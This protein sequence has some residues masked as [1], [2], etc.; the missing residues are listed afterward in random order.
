MTLSQSN[1]RILDVD[2]QTA[3]LI[4]AEERRQREKLILIPSESWTPTP[5]REALGSVLTSVY[6]EGY[7]RRAMMRQTVEQLADLDVQLANFR[8]YADRRFYKGVEIADLVESLAARRAAECFAT[9]DIPA[10]RIYANVQALSG[11]AANLAVYEAFVTPGET[12]MGMALT[13]GGHLTHGSE[14]NIT[15][16]RYR[17][18][19]YAVDPTTGR[20]D[21]DQIR[22]LAEKHRPRMIIGGFTSYPWQADWA[23]FREIADSVGAILLADVAHTA[24][25]IVGGVY[26][27]PIG[28]AHVVSFTTHKTL[29]GGRGAVLLSTDPAI[30]A[31]LDSSIFPGQQG[32]PHVNKFA[33]LAVA[34][35]LAQQ[36]EFS[37]LQRR[38]VENA[39][40]LA[41][42]LA[43]NGLTLAYGGT[44]TH[45]LLVDLRPLPRDTR[46]VMMGEIA[47]RIL[48]LAGI[49]CNKNT[50]PGDHSAADAHGIRLGTP[51]VTQRGMGEAEMR[52]LA[53]IIAD[54]LKA[55]RPFSYCGLRGDSSR[56]KILLPALEAAKRDVRELIGRV[57]PRGVAPS[58]DVRP[59]TNGG[60]SAT[61]VRG[62]RAG[63]LLQES[64]TVD[65]F[66]LPPGGAAPAYLFDEN[67]HA[68]SNVIV[69]ALGRDDY[70]LYTPAANARAVRE[71]LTGLSDGYAI[72]DLRDVLCKIQGPAVI[73]EVAPGALP[74]SAQAWKPSAAAEDAAGAD[75]REAF[76]KHP[77]RFALRKPYFVA[78]RRLPP[79]T[80]SAPPAEFRWNAA[81]EPPRR[82][83]LYDA[84]VALG[85]KL[86]PF[87]GWEMPVWYTSALEEHA[88]VRSAAGLFDLGH[89]GVFQI[90]GDRAVDFLDAV[91]SNYAGWLE[92]GQSQYAYLFDL[93]GRVID[94][95]MVYR[96]ARNRF[97]VVVNAAN[98]QK[99]WDWLCGVNEGTYLIDRE[100]PACSPCPP[101][102]IRDLKKERGVV[103]V[104]IQGPKSR[105]ILD[106]VLGPQ[107]RLAT[108]TLDRTQF[109]EV[110]PEGHQLLVART[111]YTGEPVGYEIYS[112]APDAAWL[113]SRLLDL[114]RP[115]GLLPC[116]LA[117]RDSTRTEAGLPLYG[118]ELAGPHE[119][120][121]YEAGFGSYVKLHKTFFVG[122]SACRQVYLD[123]PTRSVVRFQVDESARPIRDG[124]LMVDRNGTLLGRVTSSVS[125]GGSQV[126]L[127]LVDGDAEALPAGTAIALVNLPRGVGPQAAWADAKPGDR[128][129]LGVSGRIVPRFLSRDNTPPDP[130][131]E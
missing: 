119:V 67:G 131:G 34:L 76:S 87:A 103:D 83:P 80:P 15:G 58:R 91:T 75:I 88:A 8:R 89:M 32:G 49:V 45:L 17:I 11:A 6:A 13:E 114:G 54:V 22:D 1:Q 109:V 12:V 77:E 78:Q 20:L 14:F 97:L 61:R 68:I 100:N 16:R 59:T 35:K 10:D 99:D 44:N 55:I 101:V 130:E 121:P 117:S 104:A 129:P 106:L 84:H 113:W 46:F 98:E 72:F 24:G 60:W 27:N 63:E 81:K 28:H 47:S 79:A 110:V 92:N 111:G 90:E 23:K 95:I 86:V 123:R 96:R 5:V 128:L 30:A 126:G 65:V 21:Y 53:R 50:L 64:M 85:A 107:E 56:G 116:G 18:V 108:A 19:S 52:D 70:L 40:A 71:W 36:P 3:A 37:A 62:G 118:H 33:A 105:A 125:L 2:A 7:P 25:L 124:A 122:R 102:T 41:K 51:W 94:D 112:A 73:E 48:D 127:A 82:T 66:A 93:D 42:A 43:A 29:C 74:Q 120:N 39:Q 9:P 4:A 115:L 26:P 38:I 57:D 69:G 31:K